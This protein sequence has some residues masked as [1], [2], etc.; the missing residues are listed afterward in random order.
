MPILDDIIAQ[1][2]RE[3]ALLP[4]ITPASH[5]G[6]SFIDSLLST[7]PSLIAEI[8]PKS[9][10]EGQ[11][12]RREDVPTLVQVY[13]RH[14][15]AISVLCDER[16]FGGGFDLLAE[17]RGLTEKPLLAK[18]FIVSVTQIDHALNAGADAV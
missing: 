15:Q 11:L 8:K 6:P 3:V 2:K 17:V 5:D 10:S 4:A 18:Q 16:F 12:L 7:H 14:A 13:D 1:K 9:P